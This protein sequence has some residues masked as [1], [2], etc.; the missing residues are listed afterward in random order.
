MDPITQLLVGLGRQEPRFAN[1]T[2]TAMKVGL[3][4]QQIL[5][6]VNFTLRFYEGWSE[7]TFKWLV[8]SQIIKNSE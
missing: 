6:H 1:N 3:F 5:E 8:I 7:S 2:E 4:V